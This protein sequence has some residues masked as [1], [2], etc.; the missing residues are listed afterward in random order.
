MSNRHL[1][2]TMA[3]QCLFEWDFNGRDNNRLPE[4]I[5]YVKEEFAP[6]FDDGGYLTEQVNSVIAR[7]D[8]IDH[9]LEH[10]ALE[11]RIDDM[12]S[13]DR[14]IL[15]LGA[16]ELKFDEKIPAKVAI[17]ESIELGK[18]FS[19][20]ASGKFINGVLGAIYKDMLKKG[21]IK[22]IDKTSDKNKN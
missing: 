5:K 16:Y 22:E 14:N 2:R 7:I 1:A 19:G 4:I 11:W 13:A 21:E 18:K 10:Y 12:T 3:M 6:G 8:E 17:N 20:E 9:L 15:R